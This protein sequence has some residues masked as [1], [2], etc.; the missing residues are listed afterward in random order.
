MLRILIRCTFYGVMLG[1]GI[2]T[3]GHVMVEI[4]QDPTFYPVYTQV[5]FIIGAAYALIKTYKS[6]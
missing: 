2:F 5:V 1:C 6:K 4:K 3:T